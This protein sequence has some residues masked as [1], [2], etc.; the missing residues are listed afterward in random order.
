M[1]KLLRTKLVFILLTLWMSFQYS[2]S[3]AMS[4]NYPISFESLTGIVVLNAGKSFAEQVVYPNTIYIVNHVYDLGKKEVSI[5]SHCTFDFRGG[6]L[7]NGTLVSDGFEIVPTQRK[8]FDG[9]R[10][11]GSCAQNMNF[12]VLWFVENYIDRISDTVNIDSSVELNEAFSSGAKNFVF[13]STVFFYLKHPISI[14]GD[15]NIYRDR[16]GVVFERGPWGDNHECCVYSNEIIT[17]LEYNFITQEQAKNLTIE[18]ITFYCRKPY[19]NLK[20]IETPIVRITSNSA[21]KASRQLWGIN[22]DCNINSKLFNVT[23]GNN[24]GYV[25]SYTGIEFLANTS[26]MSFIKVKGYLQ[27]LYTGVRCKTI[28]RTNNEGQQWPYITDVT[29]EANTWCVYGGDFRDVGG[30]PVSI[31]GSHQPKPAFSNDK[32]S[33]ELGYFYGNWI[34]LYG[35]VWDCGVKQKA[36]K[37]ELYLVRYPYSTETSIASAVSG[38]SVPGYISRDE[39]DRSPVITSYDVEIPANTTN[40][41]DPYVSQRFITNLTYKCNGKDLLKNDLV[42]VYNT[43]HLFGCTDVIDNTWVANVYGDAGYIK[44]LAG[45]DLDIV[46][47]LEFDIDNSTSNAPVSRY[48]DMYLRSYG[49]LEYYVK[50]DGKVYAEGEYTEL[51]YYNNRFIKIR[52]LFDKYHKNSHVIVRNS[53]KLKKD[54]VYGLPLLYIPSPIALDKTCRGSSVNRPVFSP[55]GSHEGFI[56]YDTDLHK[57]IYWD[58]KMWCDMNGNKVY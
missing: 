55:Y 34:N 3:Y 56:Y 18:G 16:P 47:Q 17:L 4:M 10:F 54:G 21:E 24:E 8:I 43:H 51:G 26:C 11:K 29:I 58:G 12:H 6:K 9:I 15:V 2:L 27:Q 7:L 23:V 48:V 30:G 1:C 14:N 53:F 5:P 31:Y 22:I 25:P 44:N 40:L 19:K 49:K 13:P 36:K 20:D 46:L 37:G 32:E 45:K 52:H 57:P 39:M 33:A 41:L 50:R 35:F 38:S 42:K 28:K